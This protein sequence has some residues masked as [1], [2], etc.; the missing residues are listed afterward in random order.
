MVPLPVPAL[1]GFIRAHPP[2]GLA[3]Q[4]SGQARSG[5]PFVSDQMTFVVR[6]L[7]PGIE[8][9]QLVL[10]IAPAGR[11]VSTLRAGSEV[12][13]YPP[14][15]AAE[16]LAP[17]RFHAVTVAARFL[18]PQP[19]VAARTFTSAAMIA[20]LARFLDGLPAA[21][22]GVTSCPAISVTYTLAFASSAAARPYLVATASG[23]GVGVTV[24]GRAQPGLADPDS[25]IIRAAN[26][27]LAGHPGSLGPAPGPATPAPAAGA[28]SLPPPAGP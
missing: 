20:R 21:P 24:N 26:A 9:A 2:A 14:R 12:L 15:S 11:N 17:A 4:G 5:G 13:W 7:P 22:G 16:Y 27:A 23:C 3:L 25:L 18:N 19:H 28:T 8:L 6:S 10:Q 1:D